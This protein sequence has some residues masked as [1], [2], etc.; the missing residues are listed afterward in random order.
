M[1]CLMTERS[2]RDPESRARAPRRML[3]PAPVSPVTAV[4]PDSNSSWISSRRARFFILRNCNIFAG[5]HTKLE[6][7]VS[8]KKVLLNKGAW[9]VISTQIPWGIS[10]VG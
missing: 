5:H 6:L 9:S 3:L 4:K 8:L 2:V 10:S 1:P 7:G